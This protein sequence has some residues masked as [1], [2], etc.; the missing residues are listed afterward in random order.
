[1]LAFSTIDWWIVGV[2]VLLAAVPGFLCR[3][4]ILGQA[5]FLVAGRTLSVFLATATLT[6]TEMG[7]ITVMYMAEFSYR[8]GFSGM[9]VGL[10]AL[11]ATLFIGLTGFVVRGLR[12][13]GVTT[14]AEF[15]ERRY[16][17]GVRL[18]G[19]VIIATAGILNYGVFLKV[20]AEF[21]RIIT[22]VPDI[23][24]RILA[25]DEGQGVFA[26]EPDSEST[27][28]AAPSAATSQRD[29]VIQV[30]SIKLVMTVL[31]MIVLLYT[32]MGGMVSVA[33]TDYIQFIVLTLGMGGATYWVL[34]KSGIGGFQGLV[35]AV[36]THRPEFGFNPFIR[37][38]DAG[39]AM[40]GI[41]TL[42]IIW[43]AMHWLGTN[44][45]Q[46][47]AFRTVAADSASTARKMWIF[48]AFNFFGRAVIPMVW[49]LGALAFIGGT[50][51]N[52]D[53]LSA[54]PTFL[55]NLPVGLIGFLMAGMLAALMSTH[56]SY[57]LAWSGVLTEDVLAPVLRFAGYDLPQSW[58]IWITRFFILCLGAFLLLFGLW[59][60]VEG[61]VW[62]YLAVTGTIYVAGALIL[63]SA[64]LYWRGA[65]TRGAY[66]GLLGGAIPGLIYLFLRIT[67]L[68]IEPAA[69]EAGHVPEHAIAK[70]SAG[71]TE[72]VTGAIS[73][74]LAMAGMILGSWW[75]RRRQ[76]KAAAAAPT[77]PPPVI[78]AATAGEVSV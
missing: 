21:V 25:G 67:T 73:F 72:A 61:A 40:L 12:N 43:Q 24:L 26:A 54:M 52:G 32:L 17:R 23:E 53:S 28:A 33:L 48:T 14:V 16:S 64:G 50:P 59:F 3:K 39:Q 76:G 77:E 70:A 58:R 5:D 8:N 62:N 71:M 65:N 29:G 9:V 55:A 13:S 42:W 20:E 69:R 27:R 44:T 57:L 36:E 51:P 31:V 60:E 1:M 68:I 34:S 47:Q 18:L 19:G 56:S 49:G 38:E 7:L 45:W 75:G 2:Y 22:D 6:A 4:Y 37:V 46:T 15:Y 35:D 66:L 63:L 41:G 10:L 74:P 11:L 30:S 78:L